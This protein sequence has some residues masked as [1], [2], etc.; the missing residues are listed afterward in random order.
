MAPIDQLKLFL[1][2]IVL[3]FFLSYWIAR[4]L[5]VPKKKTKRTDS[6]LLKKEFV[7][8]FFPLLAIGIMNYFD[9][10]ILHRY[11]LFCF[12]GTLCEFLI[13]F[14]YH[15]TVGQRLWTY[16]RFSLNGYTSLLAIPFWGV[17]G[18]LFYLITKI[19]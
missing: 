17:G 15:R 7:F 13:G 5:F 2:L 19:L 16:H 10:T 8:V 12:V 18:L 11:L 4:I 1:L 3:S 14:S 6:S 9:S